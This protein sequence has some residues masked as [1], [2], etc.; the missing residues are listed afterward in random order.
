MLSRRRG[1]GSRAPIGAA[2]RRRSAVGRPPS[3]AAVGVRGSAALARGAPR[4]RGG[5]RRRAAARAPATPNGTSAL[6]SCRVGRQQ[7]DA[8]RAAR[9]RPRGSRPCGAGRGP[10]RMSRWCRWPASAWCQR[11]ALAPARRT[12]ENTVSRIG[13][14]RITTG[15]S[16][17]ARRRSRCCRE[18]GSSVRPPI[19]IVGTAS[20]RPRNSAPASPMMICAGLQLNGR[21][22][23]AHADRDDR[24]ERRDVRAVEVARP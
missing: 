16:E 24:D 14:P 20:S 22:P 9:S 21:K 7:R 23:D 2:R 1:A 11:L 18:N 12:N 19:V 4:P 8:P 17:R 3:P 15:M 10:R 13:T 6:P 5:S